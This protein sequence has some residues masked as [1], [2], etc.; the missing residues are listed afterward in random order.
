[1]VIK[2]VF[3]QGYG[4]LKN[5]NF[6]FDEGMNIIYGLNEAGKTTLK[7]CIVA[8]LFGQGFISENI[9]GPDEKTLMKPWHGSPYKA[10]LTYCL[11]NGKTFTVKRDFAKNTLVILNSNGID[12]T[13]DFPY[14][15]YKEPDF[16]TEQ[17][18][19]NYTSFVSTSL[20]QHD[21]MTSL[22]QP[23]I[24]SSKFIKIADE[25]SKEHSFL[26]V[27]ERL[28]NTLDKLGHP[29]DVKTPLGRVTAIIQSEHILEENIHREE[30]I[31]KINTELDQLS[32]KLHEYNQ[33]WARLSYLKGKSDLEEVALRIKELEEVEYLSKNL[34][35]KIKMAR[36]IQD[37]PRK[38]R[39]IL[40]EL[41][42]R[43]MELRAELIK[44]EEEKKL[45]NEKYQENSN[46]IAKNHE[47]LLIERE[48]FNLIDFTLDEKKKEEL[49]QAKQVDIEKAL[50]W[51]ETVKSRYKEYEKL[52]A[53]YGSAEEYENKVSGLEKVLG[54]EKTLASKTDELEKVNNQLK[55]AN[56]RGNDRFLVALLVIS[57]GGLFSLFSLMPEFI[58]GNFKLIFNPLYF[59]YGIAIIILGIIT[60]ISKK[61]INDEV[62]M[63]KQEK[64]TLENQIQELKKTIAR[65]KLELKEMFRTIGVLSVEQLRK[66]YRDFTKHKIDLETSRNLIKSLQKEIKSI[67]QEFV[68]TKDLL[69]KLIELGYLKEDTNSIT[70]EAVEKFKADYQEVQLKKIENKQ[71]KNKNEELAR[72]EDAIKSAFKEEKKQLEK[73]LLQYEIRSL[74]EY[75]N[76]L[77]YL[78][79][80]DTLENS[81]EE[82]EEKRK[83]ILDG[84]NTIED[85]YDL[86]RQLSLK[87]EMFT[88]QV[89][90]EELDKIQRDSEKIRN[91]HQ[92]LKDDIY[93]IKNRI[94]KLEFRKDFMKNEFDAVQIKEEVKKA[95]EE[96]EKLLLHKKAL[97]FALEKVSQ[98]GK[99][100]REKYFAPP[101]VI[102][103]N[104]IFRKITDKYEQ[105]TIDED[106]N[107][108]IKLPGE[109]KYITPDHLP[110][111]VLDQLYLSLRLAIVKTLSTERENLPLILDE[112]FLKFDEK[113][114][115]RAFNSL[116]MMVPQH[117][118]FLFSSHSALKQEFARALKKRNKIAK[119]YHIGNLGLLKVADSVKPVVKKEPREKRDTSFLTPLDE[120][121]KQYNIK[122][123]KLQ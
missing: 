41:W 48:L 94:A 63:L 103:S 15:K 61:N 89:N 45:L 16:I 105:L 29:D 9:A 85:L 73:I 113:R 117:Q 55:A 34:S 65:D 53:S 67:E 56:L 17:L 93:E 51:K 27:V 28:R 116:M 78:D 57:F 106:L 66:K 8:L 87:V 109:D 62:K 111:G 38:D 50:Q 86:K 30:E 84:Q 97:E 82:I 32:R 69:E 11:E 26:Q 58:V 21:Q 43:Y 102:E 115:K 95:K 99:E 88:E 83:K 54:K 80:M 47:L 110:A 121:C 44:T 96:K 59:A 13:K 112:P 12:I 42:P 90:E 70:K 68:E 39:E 119:L 1:M 92:A 6:D 108:K 64:E 118:V 120:I 77:Q 74:E 5:Q 31:E 100:F 123:D 18:G 36:R 98:T 23:H 75:E 79:E 104:A 114:T 4:C 81:L 25:A 24:L 46:F 76:V 3:I 37:I 20:I 10:M 7:R 122:N 91:S 19:V 49:I 14:N 52:F 22:N 101:M 2:K 71:L 35:E 72:Q 40:D 33:E 107:I 60:W